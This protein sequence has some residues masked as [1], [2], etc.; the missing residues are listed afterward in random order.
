[1]ATKKHILLYNS[2]EPLPQ[3]GG[4]ERVTDLLAKALLKAAYKV[5]LLCKYKNRLGKTY[6]AP[7]DILYLPEKG[8]NKHFLET[9]VA[10]RNIYCIIDQTEGG[11]VGRFGIF[12]HRKDFKSKVKLIAVQHNSTRAILDNYSLA[13][14]KDFTQM[15]WGTLKQLFY[16]N[17]YLRLKYCHSVYFTK[18]LYRDLNANYDRIV[19]LSS[20][21]IE[22]FCYYYPHVDK[23]KLLAI[24]NFNTFESCEPTT[25]QKRVLFV[26]RLRNCVKGVDKLLR[27]WNM[28][29]SSF[30][31]WSLDIVGDGKD[32]CVLELQASKLGLKHVM[33][34]GFQNPAL[35]YQRSRIFCMTSIY[36]GF[37]MVLTEAMQHGVVPM[38]FNS[39]SSVTDIIDDNVNGILVKPFDEKEYAD[40]LIDLMSDEKK[41]T[42]MSHAAMVKSALFSKE[43]IVEKWSSLIESL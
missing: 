1:M 12:R 25:A 41:Y 29:E 30:P 37:G 5:T 26:G 38:A 43:I 18:V 32:R 4:M 39:Y 28:V 16:D 33:F 19:T 8:D 42:N 35:F 31:D 40:K 15:R 27:I 11:I 7:T 2:N 20:A 10:E 9:L 24:P 13:F 23:I 6:N 36:E 34:H 14:A 22:D 21:F 17:V 3:Q